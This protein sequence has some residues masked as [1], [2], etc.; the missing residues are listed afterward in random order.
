M[1]P[2]LMLGRTRRLGKGDRNGVLDLT[3][4]FHVSAVEPFKMFRDRVVLT[5]SSMLALSGL[6]KQILHANVYFS[7]KL[8]FLS[9]AGTSLQSVA[10][11]R[12]QVGSTCPACG[13]SQLLFA[14]KSSQASRQVPPAVGVAEVLLLAL[15]CCR[16]FSFP[17]QV[18][19]APR[20]EHLFQEKEM[21]AELRACLLGP[22]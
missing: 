1:L 3:V 16:L 13:C 2:Q 19:L 6:I 14:K 18:Y 17:A 10:T 4:G 11:F 9:K 22:W 5:K 21:V 20:T 7:L 15:T 8:M 12:T